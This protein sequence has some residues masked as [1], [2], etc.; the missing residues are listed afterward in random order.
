MIIDLFSTR[1]KLA[2][3]AGQEDVYSYDDFPGPLR[4]QLQQLFSEA[5]GPSSAESYPSNDEAWVFIHKV[6][7][8]EKGVHR[9]AGA[10]NAKV[11]VLNFLG[12]SKDV[13]DVLDIC[14]ICCRY[15]EVVLGKKQDWELRQFGIDVDSQD[16]L[17]EFNHRLRRSSVGYEYDNGQ[18]VRID[19]QLIHDEVVKP[20]LRFLNRSGFEGP[21]SEFLQ[22]FTHA[23]AG[24][25]KD[26]IVWANKAFES[27]IKVICAAKGWDVPK[28][29]R[30]S[31]LLKVLR[32]NSFFPDYLDSSFDQL[33]AVLSSGL[34][35]VRNNEGGHGDG[36][37]VRE[38][39]QYV[40][41]FALH[42]AATKI[43]FLVEASQ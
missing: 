14:E 21:R 40:A 28:G 16:V 3:A 11:D 35:Q 23:K 13:M 42:L 39:P 32:R 34:P 25:N 8:R 22:A 6:L 19:S 12:N 15:I 2:A 27:T 17:A 37:A 26:A 31:D 41:A 36:Q 7:C 24:A 4:V 18:I 33:A 38:T 9:L 5:L 20:A 43:V 29:A 10:N 1:R 30:A